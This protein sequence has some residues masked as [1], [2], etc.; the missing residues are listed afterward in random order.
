MFFALPRAGYGSGERHQM[1]VSTKNGL[2]FLVFFY[3]GLFGDFT[4]LW[5]P[6]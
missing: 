2:Q 5:Y 3:V 4:D 6:L 1:T